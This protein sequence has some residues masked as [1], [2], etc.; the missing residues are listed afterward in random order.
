MLKKLQ[1]FS[2][3]V[4]S[5][6]LM[7]AIHANA[8][9]AVDIPSFPSCANPQGTQIASYGSGVHGI[10]GSAEIHTGADSVYQIDSETL[11]QCFCPENGEGIQTNWLKAISLSVDE[12]EQL[13][14]MGWVFIPT[15][16]DW[17]LSN[18][19]FVAMNSSFSCKPSGGGGGGGGAGGGG[20]GQGGAGGGAVLGAVSALGQVLGLAST[21]N[22][23]L[24][25]SL[26]VLGSLF[27][28]LGLL[29]RKLK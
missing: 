2:V 24:Y 22:N 28:T 29:L 21:G 18:D 25:F 11:I 12:I 6:F 20:G 13:K 9:Y 8:A 7:L 4:F 27:L 15:G 14:K 19:P 3:V 17:G 5:G 26:P 10:V 1:K 23:Y 16:A